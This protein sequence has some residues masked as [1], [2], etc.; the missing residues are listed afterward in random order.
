MIN[1]KEAINVGVGLSLSAD[2]GEVG[3]KESGKGWREEKE[4]EVIS[5]LFQIN[6]ILRSPHVFLCEQSFPSQDA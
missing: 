4:R 1:I 3:G 5:I 2:M 6:C